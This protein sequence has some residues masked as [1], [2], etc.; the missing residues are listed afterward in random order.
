MTN[1]RSIRLQ[2][3]EQHTISGW[4]I[5][6]AELDHEVGRLEKEIE[7]LQAELAQW[8]EYGRMI[9]ECGVELVRPSAPDKDE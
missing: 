6:A 3:P 8:V 9:K 4:G 1:T 5:R 2:N 7:R